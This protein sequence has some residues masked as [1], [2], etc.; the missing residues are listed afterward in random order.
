MRSRWTDEELIEHWTL[1]PD[2][3]SLLS[4]KS[5]PTRLG[6]AVLLRFFAGEGR[7]PTGKAEVAGQVV[8]YLAR[9][10]GVPAEEYLRYDWRGRSINYHR[11]EVRAHF[12]FREATEEDADA[13]G[14]WLLEEIL[15]P[16]SLKD[17]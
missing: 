6:F 14:R 15:P 17:G 9:Q 1:A 13:L 3:V 8:S 2:E 7:F 4:N 12:G 16:Q 5:G 10:V 11:A